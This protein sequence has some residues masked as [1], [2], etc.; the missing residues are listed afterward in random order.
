MKV[1]VENKFELKFV[2]V[3]GKTYTFNFWIDEVADLI[4]V[5]HPEVGQKTTQ[6]AGMKDSI[7]SLARIL[8]VE[9]L[10]EKKI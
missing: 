10:E 4:Q 9:L 5:E 7:E 1:S 3:D 6:I 8:F 2:D